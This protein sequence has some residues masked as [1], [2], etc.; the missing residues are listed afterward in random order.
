MPEDSINASISFLD[1]Q[2]GGLEF[3]SEAGSFETGT[4]ATTTSTPAETTSTSTTTD[5]QNAALDG[6]STASSSSVK[7]NQATLVSAL[8]GK[9]VVRTIF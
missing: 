5:T 4:S 3:G 9:S 6:Y 7:N 1:V 2:F 8:T